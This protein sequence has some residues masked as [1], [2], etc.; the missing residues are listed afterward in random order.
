MQSHSKV[1]S[2][3]RHAK[4]TFQVQAVVPASLTG[5]VT[6]DDSSES[7][8]VP[9][10]PVKAASVHDSVDSDK[11]IQ[12]PVAAQKAP[13]VVCTEAVVMKPLAVAREAA[14][15]DDKVAITQ[16]APRMRAPERGVYWCIDWLWPNH[17]S[18]VHNLLLC[19]A[20]QSPI[21][22]HVSPQMICMIWLAAFATL[23]ARNPDFLVLAW[24]SF[25]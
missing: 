23:E 21:G 13:A 14:L 6:Y 16:T 3:C 24:A 9:A 10:S 11:L 5:A 20:S 19:Q 8:S 18:V 1:L 4:I 15:E 22:R 12:A 17:H 2:G 25:M 7:P